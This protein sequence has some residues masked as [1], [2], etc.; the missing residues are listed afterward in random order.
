MSQTLVAIRIDETIKNNFDYICN[1][2]GMNMTTAITIFAKKVCREKR[3]PF[4]IS[5]DKNYDK[6]KDFNDMKNNIK[7]EVDFWPELSSPDNLLLKDME[8][9]REF[10]D[11][12]EALQFW[13]DKN[14]E[15]NDLLISSSDEEISKSC[16]YSCFQI[17][18]PKDMHRHIFTID[19]DG[20]AYICDNVRNEINISDSQEAIDVI[21]GYVRGF[22]FS[23][24]IEN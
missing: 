3:I 21:L 11:I 18:N 7:Y 6:R 5:L 9:S 12:D 8:I 20:I 17:K 2:L 13:M 10:D 16:V 15:L 14:F 23:Y 19:N 22:L 1:E 4:E 24:K